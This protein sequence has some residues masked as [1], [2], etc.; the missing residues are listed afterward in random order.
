MIETN[1][2]MRMLIQQ[3]TGLVLSAVLMGIGVCLGLVLGQQVQ[4][5]AMTPE[6]AIPYGS[7]VTI[8]WWE[9]TTHNIKVGLLFAGGALL[10]SIPTLF[11]GVLNGVWF[12][13]ALVDAWGRVS[14]WTIVAG[15]IPHG[16]VEIP[17]ILMMTAA[18]LRPL[19]LLI[20]YLKRQS[21]IWVEEVK[22]FLLLIAVACLL[23]ALS[24][25][26]EVTITPKMMEWF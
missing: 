20:H 6:A 14:A 22:Q 13:V 26:I 2:F 18:G 15:V 8:S 10:M 4:A 5:V 12:G 16:I 7:D 25:V 9:L 23:F 11:F 24:G 19:F 21:I 3:K 17:A 1:Y